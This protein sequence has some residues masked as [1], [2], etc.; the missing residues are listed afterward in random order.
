MMENFGITR[1]IFKEPAPVDKEEE[2]FRKRKP[3][4]YKLRTVLE[5]TTMERSAEFWAEWSEATGRILA[6]FEKTEETGKWL[7][8]DA[9]LRRK[10]A[11]RFRKENR[12]CNR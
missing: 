9:K 7:L 2:E 4:Y 1:T 12:R 8:E 6:H 5:N 3:L 10:D 11:E